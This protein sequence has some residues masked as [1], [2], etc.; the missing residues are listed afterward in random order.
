[1]VMR[2]GR[3]PA[4]RPPTLAVDALLDARDEA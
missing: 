1:M 2:F 3:F 4:G